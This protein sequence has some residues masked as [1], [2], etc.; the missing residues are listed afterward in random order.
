MEKH[1]ETTIQSNENNLK[2]FCEQKNIFEDYMNSYYLYKGYLLGLYC[3][4]KLNEYEYNTYMER[5]DN[6][7]QCK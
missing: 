4:L 7:I 1:F 6:I 3:A 5:L 2:K